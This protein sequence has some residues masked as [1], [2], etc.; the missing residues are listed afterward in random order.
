M[1]KVSSI[2][3][4]W[5]KVNEIFPTDYE[6][7]EGSS[8]RA[9]YPIYRSTAEGHHCDYICDLGTRLEVNFSTGKTENIWIEQ[10][11]DEPED[12]IEPTIKVVLISKDGSVR[13]YG[14]YEEFIADWRFFMSGGKPMAIETRFNRMIEMLKELGDHEAAMETVDSGLIIKLIYIRWPDLKTREGFSTP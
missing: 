1:F 10:S 12:V 8:E 14:S 11:A 5:E 6:K 4:A 9:G 7:D 2:Q 3:E 13:S